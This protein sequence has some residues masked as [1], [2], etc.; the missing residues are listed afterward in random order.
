M[1]EVQAFL[2]RRREHLQRTQRNRVRY[3]RTMRRTDPTWGSGN[4]ACPY[5]PQWRKRTT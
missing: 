1:S 4:H 2:Q 3:Q 5:V